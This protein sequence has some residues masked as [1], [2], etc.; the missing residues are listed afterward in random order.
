MFSLNTKTFVFNQEIIKL[1]K[2]KSVKLKHFSF[3]QKI[4]GNQIIK[5][6]HGNIIELLVMKKSY[7]H[8]PIK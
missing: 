3:K 8:M 6:K 2:I 5:V 1:P 4:Q 7:V